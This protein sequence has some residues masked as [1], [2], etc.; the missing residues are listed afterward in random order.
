[1]RFDE[2]GT[3]VGFGEELLHT[4]NKRYELL[5]EHIRVIESLPAPRCADSCVATITPRRRNVVVLGD[6]K[7]D[8]RMADGY[9]CQC[10]L[11]IGFLN[12]NVDANL[13]AYMVCARRCT[14]RPPAAGHV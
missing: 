3:L 7:S 2:R 5:P 10:K 13:A 14:R 12:A 4:F 9:P 8:V 6:N 11:S 1:M